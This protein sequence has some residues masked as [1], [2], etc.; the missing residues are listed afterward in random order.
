MNLGIVCFPA[1]LKFIK[2]TPN[3]PAPQF[4]WIATKQLR[5]PGLSILGIKGIDTITEAGRPRMRRRQQHEIANK[6]R[7]CTNIYKRPDPALARRESSVNIRIERGE[8]T[9]EDA[10]CEYKTH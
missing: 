7:H 9:I 3:S 10:R 2:L 5:G 8:R 6:D 1:T 4:H